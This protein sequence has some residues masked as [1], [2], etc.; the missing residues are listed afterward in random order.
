MD[1]VVDK[2]ITEQVA[3]FISHPQSTQY[4]D[5]VYKKALLHLIDCL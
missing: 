2:Y 5:L 4:N 3:D 1:Y